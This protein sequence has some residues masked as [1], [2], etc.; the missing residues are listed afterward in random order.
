MDLGN[1]AEAEA[2]DKEPG[3]GSTKSL[4]DN[5][6]TIGP[7][8]ESATKRRP[9]IVSL[10]PCF[11]WGE[12]SGRVVSGA[13]RLMC[14]LAPLQRLTV[15]CTS[16]TARQ[17]DELGLDKMHSR[18]QAGVCAA[19]SLRPSTPHEQINT[20]ISLAASLHNAC[21]TTNKLVHHQFSHLS[22]HRPPPSC[23]AGSL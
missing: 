18:L 22:F 4:A 5:R 3:L 8:R 15:R 12:Q 14:T 23:S 11:V 10:V 20:P 21:Q 1:A 19:S 13:Q 9:S 6:E 7:P 16:S 17:S 2:A